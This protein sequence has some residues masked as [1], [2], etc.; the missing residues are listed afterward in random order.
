MQPRLGDVVL[1][2][3]QQGTVRYVGPTQFAPGI[4]LGVELDGPHGKNDGSV[5]GTV[6]FYCEP[7]H[8]IFVKAD[9]A[10]VL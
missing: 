8:G 6:Y 7:L 1:A 2:R 4:W 9:A 5:Q 3:G 10:S